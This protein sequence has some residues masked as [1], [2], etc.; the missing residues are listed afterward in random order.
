MSSSRRRCKYDPDAFCYIYGEY[1]MKGLQSLLWSVRSLAIKTSLGHHIWHAKLVW[2]VY[3]DGPK[4]NWSLTLLFQ[5]NGGDQKITLM[6]ATSALMIWKDLT[7]KEKRLA[8]SEPRFCYP[9]CCVLWGSTCAC[10]HQ[11]TW[12]YGK[13]WVSSPLSSIKWWSSI[14]LFNQGELNDL[15][16]DLCL[17]KEQSDHGIIFFFKLSRMNNS[18]IKTNFRDLWHHV[19]TS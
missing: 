17:S 16:Q 6:T 7:K 9:A 1:M 4:V 12:T 15:V 2:K 8:V 5:W 18:I 19:I 13:R 10:F 11:L 3:A 14:K